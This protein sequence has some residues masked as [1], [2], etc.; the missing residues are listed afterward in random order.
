M[1][2]VKQLS[3]L[4]EN[5]QWVQAEVPVDFQQIV[6]RIAEAARAKSLD[7]IKETTSPLGSAGDLRPGTPGEASQA[8]KRNSTES[9]HPPLTAASRTTSRASVGSAASGASPRRLV[10][11]ALA[12]SGDEDA[13]QQG[14]YAVGCALMLVKMLEDYLALV[15]RVPVVTTDTLGRLVEILKILNSKT[16]QAVLGAGAMRSAGLKNITAKH[17]ALA[18]Q[19]LGMFMALVPL[20]RECMTG[21]MSPKQAVMLSELDRVTRVCRNIRWTEEQRCNLPSALTAWP[22]ARKSAGFCGA[23]NR[24]VRQAGVDNERPPRDTLPGDAGLFATAWDEVD[25]KQT[26]VSQSAWMEVLVKE[27]ST[28]HKVLG[29]YLPVDALKVGFSLAGAIPLRPV[30]VAPHGGDSSFFCAVEHAEKKN[31]FFLPPRSTSWATSLTRTRSGLRTRCGRLTCTRWLARTGTSLVEA[32]PPGSRGADCPSSG[33]FPVDGVWANPAARPRLLADIQYFLR[34]LNDLEN[35]DG[36]GS[37]LAVAVNNLKVK[38]RP[39]RRSS[40][41]YAASTPNGR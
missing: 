12:S 9:I 17:I 13:G 40:A 37:G 21:N 31:N 27:T 24:V 8:M 19:S 35:V 25:P 16:C 23:P 5:E 39:P 2:R 38:E 26:T 7:V 1:E 28:L 20:V 10:V 33:L 18:A 4:I 29:K 14:V 32:R 11:P 3:V 6:N 22:T 34:R 41:E 30:N 15:A 36:P